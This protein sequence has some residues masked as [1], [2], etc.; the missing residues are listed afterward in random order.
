MTS[1]CQVVRQVAGAPPETGWCGPRGTVA[2]LALDQ[3]ASGIPG[4]WKSAVRPASRPRT[5]STTARSGSLVRNYLAMTPVNLM[6]N[7]LPHVV[8]TP[9]QAVA[10]VRDCAATRARHLLTPSPG[11]KHPPSSSRRQGV[12]LRARW[13]NRFVERKQSPRAGELLI[14]SIGVAVPDLQKRPTACW[15]VESPPHASEAVS[16]YRLS[17]NLPA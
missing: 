2:S 3:A 5:P 10:A 15:P 11:R 1:G 14:S 7:A 6:A 13:H 4:P 9:G 12:L 17:D 8:S 16:S